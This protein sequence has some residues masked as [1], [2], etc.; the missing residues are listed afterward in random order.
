MMRLTVVLLVFAG[1]ALSLAGCTNTV[2]GLG[3]D[4]HS[5]TIQ[6]YNSRTASDM[7]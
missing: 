4:F 1:F 7:E 6:D 5:D 3:K 2:R